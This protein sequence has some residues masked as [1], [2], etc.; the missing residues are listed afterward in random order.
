V[1]SAHG[2][3]LARGGVL[4]GLVAKTHGIKSFLHLS[5]KKLKTVHRPHQNQKPKMSYNCILKAL[6]T[7]VE[8]PDL[9]DYIKHFNGP[10]GFMYTDTQ[11]CAY[12]TRL[13]E[14][15]DPHG[16]HSGGSW[17]CLLRGVQAVLNGTL[18]RETIIAQIATEDRKRAEWYERKNAQCKTDIEENC[19]IINI[20]KEF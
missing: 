4:I 12:G 17:G 9:M 15:L 14:V 10:H 1:K 20:C 8:Y 16:C 18:T 6:D 3:N 11:G 2:K 7:L 13:E 19:T 5:T